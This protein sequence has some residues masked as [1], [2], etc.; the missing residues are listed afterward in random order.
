MNSFTQEGEGIENYAEQQKRTRKLER[1][2]IRTLNELANAHRKCSALEEELDIDP[3]KPWT[4]DSEKFKEAYSYLQYRKFHQVLD[5][6]QA[7]LI[8]RFFEMSKANV[9]GLGEYLSAFKTVTT[10]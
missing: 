7:L 1:G 9:A 3:A 8:Q 5:K 2:R 6:L 10:S 4:R